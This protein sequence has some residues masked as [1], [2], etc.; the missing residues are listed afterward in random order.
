LLNM[1]RASLCPSSGAQ[2][3]N[4][5]VALC[6]ISYCGFQVVGLVPHHVSGLQNAA[7]SCKYHKQL[8]LYSTLELLM[9]GT[10]VFETC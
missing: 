5:V 6:D 9:T 8:P 2:V 10:V 4:T 7:A 3:Y 1:V